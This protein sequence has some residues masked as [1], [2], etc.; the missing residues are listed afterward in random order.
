MVNIKSRNLKMGLLNMVPS[1][2]TLLAASWAT[3]DDVEAARLVAILVMPLKSIELGRWGCWKPCERVHI[4]TKSATVTNLHTDI[5]RGC[6]AGE[7]RAI[8]VD[9]R[10]VRRGW[11]ED[12]I[13]EARA[14]ESDP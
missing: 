12:A 14:D 13:W 6:W 7:A 11:L 10:A 4:D 1:A 8:L 3:D 2:G 9:V 5:A